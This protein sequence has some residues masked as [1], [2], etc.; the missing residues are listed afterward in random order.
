MGLRQALGKWRGADDESDSQRRSRSGEGSAHRHQAD[1]H[2]GELMPVTD[3]QP[4]GPRIDDVY[5]YYTPPASEAHR[6]EAQADDQPPPVEQQA[7]VRPRPPTPPVETGPPAPPAQ[8]TPRVRTTGG[9]VVGP[10]ER[11]QAPTT[12]PAFYAPTPKPYDRSEVRRA[13]ELVADRVDRL[14]R[15]FYAELFVGLG[16]DAFD[17]FPSSMVAQREDFGRI[18]LQ[19]VVTDDP[20]AMTAHLS[21]LGADH[22]KF[23]VEPRHYELARAA[24]INS[25]HNLVGDEWTPRMETALNASYTRLASTMIDGAETHRLQPKWWDAT[26][27]SHDRVLSDFAVLTLQADAPYAFKPG[28]YLTIEIPGHG[29]EWRQM[30]I[31]SAPRAD[32]T[33]DL[34]VRSVNAT[35]VSAGLVMHTTVGDRVRLGPPRGNDLVIEAGTIRNG[36]LCVCSGTGA[37]PISA[38]VESVMSWPEYPAVYAFVGV[39]KA[40]DMYPVDQLNRQVRSAGRADHI[41]VRGVVSDDP[42]YTGL[43]GR[44][45]DVVPALKDWAQLGFDVLVSGPDAMMASTILGLTDR[46]VPPERIHFDQYDASV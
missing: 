8:R 16:E 33:L 19:W 28:Q 21:Q 14:V 38:V 37:A 43:R 25:W 45:E 40:A 9:L 3:A 5:R 2:T 23:D 10:A 12:M 24:L 34:Q 32:N 11:R 39:R 15:N 35:G 17:M 36:L 30:S 7:P 29:R 44:V 6:S 20:D 4:V 46:G 1:P 13:F 41:Q 27:V 18:L 22:R 26:V 42:A 31:A